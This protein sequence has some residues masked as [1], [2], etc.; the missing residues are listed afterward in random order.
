MTETSNQSMIKC[1]WIK[2]HTVHSEKK[3]LTQT[4]REWGR[5]KALLPDAKC[6]SSKRH[7]LADRTTEIS[8]LSREGGRCRLGWGRRHTEPSGCDHRGINT[9]MWWVDK[10]CL[11]HTASIKCMSRVTLSKNQHIYNEHEAYDWQLSGILPEIIGQD[12]MGQMK[13]SLRTKWLA[14]HKKHKRH[15]KVVIFLA[16]YLLL[17]VE[18]DNKNS[19]SSSDIKRS[20]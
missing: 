15:R 8:R 13:M 14:G 19:C 12:P 4:V 17:V 18:H 11:Y 7:T 9:L 5:E 3:N 20:V 1:W 2:R 10:T 16:V 6:T